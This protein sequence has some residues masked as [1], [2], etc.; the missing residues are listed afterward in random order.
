M[1]RTYKPIPSS[2]YTVRT[3]NAYK[4][5]TFTSAGTEVPVL[6]AEDTTIYNPTNDVTVTSTFEYNKHTLYGQL[7]ASFYSVIDTP[8]L[9]GVRKL[10][11]SA[12]VLP[13]P[14]ECI[15]DGIKVGSVTIIDDATSKTLT[16]NTSGSL[17]DG[18]TV[19]GDIFYGAGIIVYTDT[20]TVSTAFTST[21]SL[22]YRSTQTIT[23]HEI[24]LSIDKTEFN[25]TRNPSALYTTGVRTVDIVNH[26]TGQ[27]E[28][29]VTFPG[30]QF[31]RKRTVTTTG[32]VYDYRY[33]SRVSAGVS[34][35][36]EH[37][38]LSASVDTTGSFLTPFVTTIGMYDN[39]N[40]LVAVAKLPQPIKMEPT[41]P[42]NFVVRFDA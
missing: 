12:K 15:G 17:M 29:V 42:I 23:E 2:N 34:G 11:T 38:Y 22:T 27:T 33:G 5:F 16:D 39:N 28:T 4:E 8:I 21:W 35:G 25:M 32:T 13:V 36:F 3:F 30:N 41:L 18:T 10:G 7:S 9:L 14:N 37:Y 1:I 40:E 6:L 31:I 26:N 20:S 19:V 24:L